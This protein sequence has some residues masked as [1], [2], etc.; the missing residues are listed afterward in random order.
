RLE[1][2]DVAVVI[3][4]SATGVVREAVDIFR[5]KGVKAG[6]VK[7]RA[8]R[9]FPTEEL[10]ASLRKVAAVAVL[11]RAD[12]PGAQGGPLFLDVRSALYDEE[13]RPLI[14]SVIYGLGGRD[15]LMEEVLRIFE[16]LQKIAAT[17][18]VD[19]G[20]GYLQVRV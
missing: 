17:G 5:E 7:I 1:D 20:S 16:E 10:C 19:R 6:L 14:K 12:A 8:Y 18:R 13:E 4:G 15:L 11:D 2:A 9:P 3:M